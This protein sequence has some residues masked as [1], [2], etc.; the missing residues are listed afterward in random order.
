M[1]AE[2]LAFFCGQSG[3]GINAKPAQ[4]GITNTFNGEVSITLGFFEAQG[5]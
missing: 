1:K 5:V 2:E 3:I 4:G